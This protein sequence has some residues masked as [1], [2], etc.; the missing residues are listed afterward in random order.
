MTSVKDMSKGP[1]Q[2]ICKKK[3]KAMVNK[4]MKNSSSLLI[5]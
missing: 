2:I 4:N 5:K 1:E 3:D